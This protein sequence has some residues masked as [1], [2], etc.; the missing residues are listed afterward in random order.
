[1]KKD[2]LLRMI[3]NTIVC[4]LENTDDSSLFKGK[5]GV[6]MFLY[7]YSDYTGYT[8]YREWA[9]YYLQ[10]VIMANISK[11]TTSVTDGYSGIGI[12]ICWLI[13]EGYLKDDAYELLNVFD[14][15]LLDNIDKSIQYDKLYNTPCCS[16]RI[17]WKW[18]LPLCNN[19]EKIKWNH[20][21]SKALN[22]MQ[23][24]DFIVNRCNNDIMRKVENLW[25]C[26]I[27]KRK[28]PCLTYK[29]LY[30]IVQNVQYNY[31]YEINRGLNN[32]LSSIGLYI[33]KG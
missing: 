20:K 29:E 1:M 14:D 4:N 21:V 5:M 28:S 6:C 13:Q 17:Y 2:K 12:G 25:W 16:S 15:L 3:A 31:I 33:I 27:M 9:N 26:F 19:M 22:N 11:M 23:N 18:R 30:C 8:E 7:A 10:D 24:E 32:I